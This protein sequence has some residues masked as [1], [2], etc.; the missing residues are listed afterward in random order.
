[1]IVGPTAAGKTALSLELAESL[2]AEIVSMDSRLLYRGM[3]VGTAKP[4]VEERRRV[5]HHLIDVADPD[6]T[7]SLAAYCEA[8]DQAIHAVQARGVLPLLVGGTGQYYRAMVEGWQPPR[9]TRSDAFRSRMAEYVNEHGTQALHQELERIDPMSAKRIDARNV[10]RVVRALEIFHLTGKTA[11]AQR[12]KRPP[13]YP[14]LVMG[15]S[16]PRAEL[17]ERIDM[18]ID[19]MLQAGWVGEVRSLLEKG[20]SPRLPSFSA[21]GYREIARHVAGEME[22]DQA[23]IQI[24]RSSR[25]FVRRQSNW[26][27]PGDASIMWF[28]NRSGVADE[29]RHA[30]NQWRSRIDET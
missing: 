10:R 12:H 16:L 29:M 22:L 23:Q 2:A 1:V 13:E 5:P 18:R 20:Y 9:A 24:Q 7:W 21:I 30:I 17:Y 11:S 15:V 14:L 8:A 27:K 6:Q 28:D 26:F 4:T 19:H 25:Q 3:D